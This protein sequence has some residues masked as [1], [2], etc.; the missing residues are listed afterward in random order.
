M[1][2]NKIFKNYNDLFKIK[3]NS[4]FCMTI[5]LLKLFLNYKYLKIM[6]F[7]VGQLIKKN[8]Y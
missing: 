1:Y 8:L 7:I 2:D 5:K 4:K 3:L 6:Q